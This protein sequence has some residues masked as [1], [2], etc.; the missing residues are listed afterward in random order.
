[1]LP[2]ASNMVLTPDA[3]PTKI[4]ARLSTQ[5]LTEVISVASV[6]KIIP[7]SGGVIEAENLSTKFFSSFCWGLGCG[8]GIASSLLSFVDTSTDSSGASFCFVKPS[9]LRS[10]ASAS[11][12]WSAKNFSLSNVSGRASYNHVCHNRTYISDI[13]FVG[14]NN[15]LCWHFWIFLTHFPNK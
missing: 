10:L 4:P 13:L 7:L 12:F 11:R 9:S 6:P 8:N 5:S 1:M 3:V 14:S 15:L 2:N